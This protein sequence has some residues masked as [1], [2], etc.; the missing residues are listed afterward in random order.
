MKSIPELQDPT[1]KRPLQRTVEIELRKW[2]FSRE[3]MKTCKQEEKE[4]S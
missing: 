1:P 3:V 2:P 4:N